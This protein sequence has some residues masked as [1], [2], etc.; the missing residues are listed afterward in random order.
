M[1]LR[2]HRVASLRGSL[3]APSDKS[4]SHRAYLLGSIADGTSVVKNVLQGE[5]C[6]ATRECLKQLGCR[7]E[8]ISETEELVIPGPWRSPAGPLDCG[9]SGTTM[10]LLA[11]LI[12]GHDVE[13]RL[14]GDASL[15]RRPMKRIAEPLRMM[16]AQIEGDTAPLVIRGGGL[17]GIR[18]ETPVAS[19]QIKSAILLAGL[20]AEGVAEVREPASS[21]DHTERML[22]ACGVEVQE[23]DGW[24]QVRGSGATRVSRFEFDVPSDISSAAFWL[25]AGAMVPESEL[26]LNDVGINPSRT[27]I[28]DVAEQ[29]G[30]RHQ[31]SRGSDRLG[32][33][34]ADITVWYSSELRPFKISGDLVPRLIDEIPIL[35]V[36]ATQA[37]GTSVIRDA[38]ELRVKE[39]DRIETMACAL[40]K[41]GATI[42]TYSDGMAISGPTPLHGAEFEVHGDHRVAMSLAIA[43]L[44]ADGETIIHGAETISSSYPAFEQD[45]WRLAVV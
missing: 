14:V 18:Y 20:F 30:I 31:V 36:L 5:D 40:G 15:S 13:A 37:N 19:A 41:M 29:C 4:L 33:P 8:R 35:A 43:G 26:T 3:R 21:R 22:R 38:S 1:T 32:E 11:G 9:N 12:A 34:V 16:G 7:F 45:L 27:G 10:R 23:H 2:T 44:I 24:I 6:Q 39:S 42:E 28:L 25:V 17:K